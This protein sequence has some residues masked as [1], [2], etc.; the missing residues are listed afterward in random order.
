MKI[1][2]AFFLGLL[3]FVFTCVPASHVQVGIAINAD[4]NFNELN[5]YGEWV[6]VP[7]YGTVWRPDAEAGWRP[8]E[9]GHWVYSNEGWVWDSDEP[10]GWIVCHYGT[11]DNDPEQGWVWIPGYTWSPAR[12]R[13]YVTDNEIGWSPLFSKPRQGYRQNRVQMSWSFCPVQFFTASQMHE[14][15]VFRA[16]PNRNGIQANSYTSPPKKEFVQRIAKAP[17]ATIS[18]NKVSVAARAKP[19]IKVEVQNQVRPQIAVPVGPKYKRNMVRSEP[20]QKKAVTN[21]Q[22]NEKQPVVKQEQIYGNRVGIQ[23][24][25]DNPQNKGRED[26]PKNRDDKND[27]DNDQDNNRH[28]R[29]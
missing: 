11:W 23:S 4:Q 6:N 24:R 13:W 17:I 20:E 12:V 29:R 9:Y 1:R 3:G 2:Y 18:L 22:E 21:P 27:Q 25:P 7:G 14:H 8:F 26:A 10:Y 5:E 15:A 28:D 19:L 16:N